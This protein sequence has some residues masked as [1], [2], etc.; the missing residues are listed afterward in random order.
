MDKA[1]AYKYPQVDIAL[2]RCSRNRETSNWLWW[3]AHSVLLR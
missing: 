1:G 2:C 3:R